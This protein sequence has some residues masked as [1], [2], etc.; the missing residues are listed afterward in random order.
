ML[1]RLKDLLYDSTVGLLREYQRKALEL[2]KITAAS[3]YIEGVKKLRQYT[4]R[5]FFGLL[6]IFVLAMV[7]VVTPLAFIA[8]GPWSPMAKMAALGVYALIYLGACLWALS[9][10]FS[11]K[12]WLEF[13]RSRQLLEDLG[14]GNNHA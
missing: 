12:R 4:L 9:D 3:F 13:S 5:L 6:T 11:E 2:A 8:L 1:K 10:F 14:G 7:I